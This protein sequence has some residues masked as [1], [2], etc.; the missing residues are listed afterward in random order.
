M[1]L[2]LDLRTVALLSAATQH[3]WEA[4]VEAC[5]PILED[6]D[7]LVL[8]LDNASAPTAFRTIEHVRLS[9]CWG[10]ASARTWAGRRELS[11]WVRRLCPD[12]YWSADPLIMPPRREYRATRIGCFA[13]SVEALKPFHR[14]GIFTR[15]QW[16][17]WWLQCGRKF[18]S[19]DILFCPSHVLEVQLIVALGLQVRHRVRVIPNGVLPCFRPYSEEEVLVARRRWLVPKRYVL[20]IEGNSTPEELAVPLQALACNEE[21]SSVAC[22]IVGRQGLSRKLQ[23]DVRNAHLEGLV[24]FVDEASIS[25]KDLAALYSGAVATL[26]PS[27]QVEEPSSVLQSMACG[28]PVICAATQVCEELFGR[29]VLRVHPTDPMEWARALV[30]LTLSLHLR[31]RLRERGFACAAERTWTATARASLEVWRTYLKGLV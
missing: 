9:R 12:G 7:R 8:L 18:C 25:H 11:L 20:M 22:V 15:W 13:F 5:V 30:M 31:E 10:R 1:Q 23:E 6:T 3:Y 17:R 14:E 27:R 26:E 2:F 21:V 16:L 4:V 24:R 29:A 28:T 19:A